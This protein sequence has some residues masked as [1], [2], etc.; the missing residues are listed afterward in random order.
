MKEFSLPSEHG[1]LRGVAWDEVKNPIGTVQIAHGLAEYHGRYNETARFLNNLGY[2]VFCNDHL[3]HGLHISDGELKGFFKDEN[4]YDAVVDQLA[5]MNSHIRK[6]Y[7]SLNHY[8]LSHSLGTPLTL[9]LLQRNVTFN[10][11]VLS[12]A[13]SISPLFLLLNKLLLWPEYTFNDRKSL[14]NEMEKHTTLKHNSFFEPNRTTHDFLSRDKRKVDEYIQDPLCGFI[15]TIQLWKDLT[16]G[17]KNLWSK[18]SFLLMDQN[19][20]FLV[21]TGD[22]DPIN[23]NGKQAQKI[24]NLLIDCGFKTEFTSFKGM[25]H[26]PLTELDRVSVME[27]I[28][29]FFKSNN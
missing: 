27:K 19:I 9:S 29:E 22:E 8:I 15:K 17:F 6:E 20:P 3:G 13:F 14:S 25:R 18:K 4:G 11:V 23:E 10:G 12:A 16:I 24:S 28:S 7:P 2:S 21:F 1:N 5:E 26:E